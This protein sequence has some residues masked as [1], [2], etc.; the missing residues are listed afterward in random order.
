M[1]TQRGQETSQVDGSSELM[2]QPAEAAPEEVGNAASGEVLEDS[3]DE[4]EEEP[5][6]MGEDPGAQIDMSRTL[7]A[8]AKGE[9]TNIRRGVC[10]EIMKA[11]LDDAGVEAR[12]DDVRVAYERVMSIMSDLAGMY[13]AGNEHDKRKKLLVEMEELEHKYSYVTDQLLE[14]MHSMQSNP[15]TPQSHTVT[16]SDQ[17]VNTRMHQQDVESNAI[18]VSASSPHV[19]YYDVHGRSDQDDWVDVHS[20]YTGGQQETRDTACEDVRTPA[21]TEVDSVL[22]RDVDIASPPASSGEHRDSYTTRS[23]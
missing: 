15:A 1:E 2:E 16:A 14:A 18:P 23:I 7:K 6:D 8:N 21:R 12:L 9:F 17:S 11:Q 19:R 22:T 13:G 3:S 10:V 4:H 20:V 5:T